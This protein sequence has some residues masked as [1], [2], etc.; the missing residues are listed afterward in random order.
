M[1][2]ELTEKMKNGE[3]EKGFYYTKSPYGTIVPNTYKL[4]ENS[5]LFM[6]GFVDE[7]LAPVPSYEELQEL[8][9]RV[10][11]ADKTIKHFAEKNGRMSAIEYLNKWGVK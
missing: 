4:V 8:K 5:T 9:E 3:L 10:A 1:S 11:D 6:F 2:K 7:V